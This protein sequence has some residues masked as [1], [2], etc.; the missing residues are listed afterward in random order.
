MQ[1]L[2]LPPDTGLI[3]FQLIQRRLIFRGVVIDLLD[4]LVGFL[5]LGAELL[6]LRFQFRLDADQIRPAGFQPGFLLLDL[7]LKIL[8]ILNHLPVIVHDLIYDI[9]PAQQV[10]KAGGLEQHRPVAHRPLLLHLPHPL[11][12]QLILG[13]LPLL[14]VRQLRFRLRNQGVVV[15]DLGF[16]VADFGGGIGD[17]VIQQALFLDGRRLIVLQIAELALDLFLLLVQI[18]GVVFQCV[19][20][21]LRDLGGHSRGGIPRQQQDGAQQR[22]A[23][24]QEAL[25]FLHSAPP[26]YLKKPPDGGKAAAYAD[27]DTCPQ[28]YAAHRL[29]QLPERHDG[30]QL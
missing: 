4:Q 20:I 30:K 8:K 2:R 10:G 7:R 27:Q 11:A 25:M 21:R 23:A 22:R 18:G 29:P 9:Q 5:P 17:L 6:F 26:L 28:K 14:S 12:E 16:R 13:F 19:D 15:G 24:P 3:G 1:L